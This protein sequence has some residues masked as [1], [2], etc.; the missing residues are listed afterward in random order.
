MAYI[1]L[2]VGLAVTLLIVVLA[3]KSPLPALAIVLLGKWRMFAVKPRFWFKNLQSNLVDI[4][5]GFSIVVFLYA[6][7]GV[8]ALQIIMTGLYAVWLL[9]IK[10][11]SRRRYVAFQ[12]GAALFIGTNALFM[13]S[14]DWPAV[15][16][17][18]AMWV[19]GYATARHILSHYRE[20]ERTL[21]SMIWGLVVAEIGWLC[22]HWAF[23]YALPGFAGIALS[24][25]ALIVLVLGFLATMVYDSYHQ[26]EGEIRMN[27]IM[28][29]TIFS[30]SIIII[31][32]LFFNTAGTGLI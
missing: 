9:F 2:N 16:V 18:L 19:I 21:L 4:I 7:T 26:N 27:D 11:R 30:M 15:V 22:Y 12:A 28:L 32:L 24:Q 6:A 20:S 29:P 13:E 25:T 23:A 1:A 10:P 31:V 8:L 3:I 5:V 14:A 17:V